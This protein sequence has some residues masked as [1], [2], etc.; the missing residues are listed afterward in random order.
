MASFYSLF[1]LFFIFLNLHGSGALTALFGCRRLVPRETAAVSTRSVYT[2]HPCTMP[3]CYTQRHI[4]RVHACLTVTCHLHFR[5]N[6]RGLLRATAITRG[7]S[8]YRNKSA[9]NFPAASAW[10]RTS[11][12]LSASPALKPLSSSSAEEP[13]APPLD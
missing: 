4:G 13:I 5:Q 11:D 1:I 10:T 6:D 7:W 8:G 9:Q 2:I 3:R 12:L